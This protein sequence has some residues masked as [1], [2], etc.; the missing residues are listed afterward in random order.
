MGRGR[1]SDRTAK[2]RVCSAES[3]LVGTHGGVGQKKRKIQLIGARCAGGVLRPLQATLTNP[4]LSP[5]PSGLLRSAVS[6]A[7]DFDLV[8]IGA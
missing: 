5:P 1:G 2:D 4:E 8:E 7:V 3:P 6:S